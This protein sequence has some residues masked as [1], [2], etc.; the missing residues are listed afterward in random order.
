MVDCWLTLTVS[1]LL[2]FEIQLLKSCWLSYSS[3]FR[4]GFGKSQTSIRNPQLTNLVVVHPGKIV[5]MVQYLKPTN[6]APLI[7][8]AIL[9]DHA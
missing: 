8:I 1:A 5:A 9:F 7:N 6:I 3:N 4:V 2:S